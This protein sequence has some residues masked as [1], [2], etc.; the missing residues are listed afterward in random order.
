MC[1]ALVTGGTCGIGAATAEALQDAGL[2]YSDV[3]DVYAGYVY[4]DS[5]SGQ[6]AVYEVVLESQL[7][8]I[9]AVKPGVRYR[10]VHDTA[11]RVLARWL[12]DEGL[13]RCSVDEALQTGA[14]GVFYPH[15][16]GHHL[17]LDVHDLEN[18]GDLPSYPPGQGRPSQFGTQNLRLDLPLERDW[19]V[20]IEPG[21]AKRASVGPTAT[22]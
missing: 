16:T 1:V 9:A 15:G 3:Q 18:F 5:A 8:A 10:E 2:T 12:I 21:R 20:T 17:G 13:L 6:R 7:A 14:H 19:V 4:G 22:W 11:C